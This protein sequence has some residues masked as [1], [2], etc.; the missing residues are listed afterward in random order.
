MTPQEWI[1]KQ[2]ARA[3]ALRSSDVLYKASTSTMAVM[4]ERIWRQGRLTD[5]S[6]L[7]YKEDY[8]VWMY[9][10]PFPKK[11]NG[12]GK[13][14]DLWE[15][16]GEVATDRAELRSL[17]RRAQ[18]VGR[19]KEKQGNKGKQRKIEGQWA[20]TYL[21]A[22]DS[23]GRKELPFELTGDMRIAWLGGP[24]PTPRKVSGLLVQIVM[25]KKEYD[26]AKGLEKTK[27]EFLELTPFEIKHQ[28]ETLE[29]LISELNL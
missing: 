16:K 28:A 12:K 21:A 15:R 8:E 23:Q 27:G 1:A 5:G 29:R 14:F 4:S 20:P 17:T 7:T 9:K 25:P 2:R 22:K 18:Q 6:Q 24:T 19:A 26:K 10:P 11:P 13:P 3:D